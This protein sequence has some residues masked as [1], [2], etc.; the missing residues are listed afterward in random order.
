M[1]GTLAPLLAALALLVVPLSCGGS[2]VGSKPDAP[3]ETEPR[4][5]PGAAAE[6]PGEP[7][8]RT[9]QDC[10]PSLNL[11]CAATPNDCGPAFPSFACSADTDCEPEQRCVPSGPPSCS[12]QGP[13]LACAAPCTEASC[14]ASERCEADGH[15]RPA[16]CAEGFQCP[17]DKRCASQDED[18]A[19]DA[20]GCA[21]VSCQEGFECPNNRRCE[22]GSLYA[23]ECGPLACSTD[24]DC[25]CGYCI[26]KWCYDSL[27]YCTKPPIG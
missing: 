14:A 11:Y 27:F 13:S 26:G 8:C 22:P 6:T 16:P 25:D 2:T 12:G 24:A 18:A 5:C 17:T 7:R 10:D 19:A 21:D 4:V 3:L 9:Q 1:R 15:C 20:N 23:H